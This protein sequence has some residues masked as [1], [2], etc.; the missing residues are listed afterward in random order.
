MQTLLLGDVVVVDNYVKNG[1]GVTAKTPLAT[2]AAPIRRAKVAR[3]LLSK[4]H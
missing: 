4:Q 3:H 1:S 2:N